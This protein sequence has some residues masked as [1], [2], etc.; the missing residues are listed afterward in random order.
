[1]R[2]RGRAPIGERCII[3]RKAR[4]IEHL[5]CITAISYAFGV[6]QA[7]FVEGSVDSEIFCI[8][9]T[10]LFK[11]LADIGALQFSFIM[12][13]AAI[14]KT[15]AVYKLCKE[16]KVSIYHTP[17]FSCELN[18]IE[19]V[20]GF[21]KRRVF[22]PLD[23]S[24]AVSA[25]PHFDAAFRQVSQQE[26]AS[27]I[28]MVEEFIMPLAERGIIL[29]KKVAV[30]HVKDMIKASNNDLNQIGNLLCF[31][32]EYLTNI[33]SELGLVLNKKIK[34]DGNCLYN[35]IYD[36]ICE[37]TPTQLR[38]QAMKEMLRDPELYMADLPNP[39]ARAKYINSNSA[40]GVFASERE[41]WALSEK[42]RKPIIIYDPRNRLQPIVNGEDYD[43][44]QAIYLGLINNNHFLSMKKAV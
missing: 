44:E 3:H 16:A 17:P 43:Q 26:V 32:E 35:S 12:D 38:E 21:L 23:V 7:T 14:H 31:E 24:S 1:M 19:L 13:N 6:L 41:A 10:S 18:P 15:A 36:I 8:F 22:L 39:K 37:D 27:S 5:S 42:L 9:L 40:N 25:V 20:F 11:S 34:G 2:Q 4:K 29:S 28:S 30:S 33:A